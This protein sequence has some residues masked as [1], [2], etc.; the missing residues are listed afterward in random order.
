M[1]P[2]LLDFLIEAHAAFRL[3]PE[4]LYLAIN[5]LDRYCSKR[6]V[7]KKHYQLVGCACLFVAAKYGDKKEH[8][9][10]ISELKSMCCGLYEEEMFTQMEWH[11]LQT[12]DWSIGHPTID[13]FL[14]IILAE[15]CYDAE[16]E[17]MTWYLCEISLFHRE[18]VA[19]LPSVMARTALALARY[20]LSRPLPD[21]ADWSGRYDYDLLIR[22]SEMVYQP[23]P[24]VLKKFASPQFSYV[25]NTMETFLERQRQ[26]EQA[27]QQAEQARQAAEASLNFEIG[28]MHEQV[29]V[30]NNNTLPIT[31]IKPAYALNIYNGLATPPITPE[32]DLAYAAMYGKAA[33][34]RCP[35]T[36]TPPSSFDCSQ[37]QPQPPRYGYGQI[38]P[39]QQQYYM[40]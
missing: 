8:V 5:L 35:T 33:P 20:V 14:Q 28:P 9:P 31:P 4:T 38:Q 2:F 30:L 1:R 26:V 18:F 16:L 29:P 11:V 27:R 6:V 25:S 13:A 3:L 34:P 40:Q 24:V 17:H 10:R 7:Y 19:V 32:N 12:L 22:L 39:A 23:S 37:Y 15:D 36:P 21:Q